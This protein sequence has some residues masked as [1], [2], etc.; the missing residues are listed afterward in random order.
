MG[1]QGKSLVAEWP[2]LARLT[3]D[4]DGTQVRLTPSAGA[5]PRS[6]MKLR[7]VVKALLADLRGGLGIHASAVAVRSSAVLLLGESGAGKSTTAAE[8]CLHH[9]ARL[10]ADDA[11]W[12]DERNGVVQVV[13]SEDRH[14]LTRESGDALGVRLRSADLQEAGKAGVRSARTATRR[15]RLGLV[16]SLHFDDTLTEAVSR[17]LSGAE[18]A[19]RVLG[20]MFRFD[21]DDRREELDRVMRL[22]EQ[23]PFLEIARPRNEPAIAAHV[24]R[25]LGG[26][27]GQ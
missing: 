23:A 9:G 7:G 1:R 13:P 8:L 15:V 6:L 25:A 12:L 16:V 4:E 22:Y 21:V 14:Y 11:A 20:A 26:S 5:S 19:F 17:R 27:R 3:C 24:V 2:R 18:A 10:L